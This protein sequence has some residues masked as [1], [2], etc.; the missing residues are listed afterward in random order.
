MF[1]GRE[2]HTFFVGDLSVDSTNFQLLNLTLSE[3]GTDAYCLAG[4]FDPTSNELAV[5]PTS[6]YESH[7]IICRTLLITDPVCTATTTFVKQ[8]TFDLLLDPKKQADKKRAVT[9]N[10]GTK[11]KMNRKLCQAGTKDLS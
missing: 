2:D 7:G 3:N 9:Q 4:Q 8:N 5:V 10:A 6:C 1:S 11:T